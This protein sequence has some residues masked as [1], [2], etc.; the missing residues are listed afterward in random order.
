MVV[1]LHHEGA[2][3][4]HARG[5]L[6]VVVGQVLAVATAAVG[7]DKEGLGEVVGTDLLE[8]IVLDALGVAKV[9][10]GKLAIVAL[11]AQAEG[12]VGV[13][14]GLAAHGLAIPIVGGC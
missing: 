7:L 12:N 8:H 3:E 5:D 6:D 2:R 9:L 14:H 11:D 13:D 4:A 10:F 1:L